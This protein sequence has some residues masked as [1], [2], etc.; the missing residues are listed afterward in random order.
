M[1]DLGRD[2][3]VTTV[4]ARDYDERHGVPL[5]KLMHAQGSNATQSA[6]FS[7]TQMPLPH[8]HFVNL[9]MKD[10]VSEQRER[11]IRERRESQTHTGCECV[12]VCVRVCVSE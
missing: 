7:A 10:R 8:F 9:Q 5:Q 6:L 4:Q 12:C 1:T 11:E 3:F 2:T